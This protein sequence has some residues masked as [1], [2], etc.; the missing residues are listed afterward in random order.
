VWILTEITSQFET[1]YRAQLKVYKSIYAGKH[2]HVWS[3]SYNT[4]NTGVACVPPSLL[5]VQYGSHYVYHVVTYR[6]ISKRW[7]RSSKLYILR[8]KIIIMGSNPARDMNVCIFLC[9]FVLEERLQWDDIPFKDIGHFTFVDGTLEW[10]SV[11]MNQCRNISFL[12]KLVVLLQ[13]ASTL[14][15]TVSEYNNRCCA[16]LK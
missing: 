9:Y 4:R 10:S 13:S 3:H 12:F 8:S 6:W 11:P 5:Y 7:W 16:C 2:L 14:L 15:T 1:T